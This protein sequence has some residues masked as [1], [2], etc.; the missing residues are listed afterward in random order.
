MTSRWFNVAIV[1][2]WTT[3][4]GWLVCD[5]VLPA[6]IVGEPPSYRSI[7]SDADEHL[8]PVGWRILLND[9]RLGW[10]I[11]RAQRFE[12]G[13][14]EFRTRVRLSRLP[15]AAMTPNWVSSFLR[16]L[17]R[18]GELPDLRLEVD[19]TTTI[20]VDPLGRLLGL[21]SVATLGYPSRRRSSGY[22]VFNIRMDG[23]VNNSYLDLVVKS[24]D[25]QYSTSTYLSVDS[26]V[27]DALSPQ[28]RLPNLKVGQSWTVPIY[29]P[30][31][32]PSSPM[33]VLQA[34]V[35]R[36]DQIRWEE[37][38]VATL[39]VEYSADSGGELSG[40]RTP[41]GRAWVTLDGRVLRQELTFG[42]TH[43]MFERVGLDPPAD[44]RVGKPTDVTLLRPW[45]GIEGINDAP[46]EPADSTE[47]QSDVRPV[48]EATR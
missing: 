46:L 42:S 47:S 28:A 41:Q 21:N 44:R 40:S 27:G 36:R 24:G 43:L 10:A 37:M 11:S 15:V 19:A 3:T 30:F 48:A 17:Q 35:V 38:Y 2:F 22:E 20:D 9:R 39:V 1:V 4:M 25:L 32:P 45:W 34:E 12:K 18:A 29:S 16:M 33:E 13:G 14:H 23:T 6:L 5:K 8:R 31:R 26:L 7:G